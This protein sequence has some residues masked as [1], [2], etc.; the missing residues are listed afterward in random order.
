MIKTK[1]ERLTA[2]FLLIRKNILSG[3]DSHAFKMLNSVIN[4][5]IKLKEKI[6]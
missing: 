5:E 2:A 6:K 1:K 3:S 4:T